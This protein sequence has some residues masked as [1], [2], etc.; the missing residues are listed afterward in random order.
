MIAGRN[1]GNQETDFRLFFSRLNRATA[2]TVDAHPG[3]AVK[4][5]LRQPINFER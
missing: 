3:V 5:T 2:S 4:K 1:A